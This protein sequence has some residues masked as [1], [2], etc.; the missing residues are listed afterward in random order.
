MFQYKDD[1]EIFISNSD[2]EK[3]NLKMMNFRKETEQI[4]RKNTSFNGKFNIFKSFNNEKRKKASLMT[5]KENKSSLCL[6][7][8]HSILKK[9]IKKLWIFQKIL[10]H[11]L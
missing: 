1:S 5:Y 9:F 4:S 8:I 7:Y 10:N 2:L 11:L 6:F 3:L